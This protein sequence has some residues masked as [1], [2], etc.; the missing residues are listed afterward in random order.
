MAARRAAEASGLSVDTAQL[1]TAAI[2]EM[3]SNVHEHSAFAASGLLAFQAKL[4]CFEFVVAD[5]GDGILATLREALEFQ[6]LD[7]HGRALH[8]ALQEG[9]SRWA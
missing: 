2:K 7:D 4:G 8:A 9:V 5:S 6:D 3:E 1:L